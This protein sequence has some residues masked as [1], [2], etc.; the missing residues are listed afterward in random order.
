MQK[1][2][3]YIPPTVGSFNSN[4]CFLKNDNKMSNGSNNFLRMYQGLRRHS[5]GDATNP[6]PRVLQGSQ[7]S[8]KEQL[9]KGMMSSFNS[10]INA[11]FK[12]VETNV[13]QKISSGSKKFETAN[14]I[15]DQFD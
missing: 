2:M 13:E 10:N 1:S 9:L 15:N 5:I 3:G 11:K 8:N 7:I 6:N 14:R 4:G 12:L